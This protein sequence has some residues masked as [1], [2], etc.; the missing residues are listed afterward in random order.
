[1]NTFA[2]NLSVM[3]KRA[4][5][6]QEELANKVNVSIDTI[7]RWEGDKQDP[8]LNDLRLIAKVLGVNISQLVGE[9]TENTPEIMQ[10]KLVKHKQ[11]K[12]IKKG[13]IIIQ[14]GN[15]NIEFPATPQGYAILKEKLKEI[16]ISRDDTFSV[17]N[18]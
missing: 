10:G 1:M 8:R 5:L 18:E 2:E 17:I 12:P 4:G 16:S 14:H 15:T 3:R 13:M 7:R 6:T 11:S 9:D